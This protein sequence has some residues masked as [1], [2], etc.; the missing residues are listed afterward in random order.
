MTKMFTYWVEYWLV[1][2]NKYTGNSCTAVEFRILLPRCHCYS[3]GVKTNGTGELEVS[4]L[5][6]VKVTGQHLTERKKENK[7]MLGELILVPI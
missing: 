4:Y 6:L 2:G 1:A 7:D 3:S 5:V